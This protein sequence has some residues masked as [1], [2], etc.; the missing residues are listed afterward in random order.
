MTLPAA[1]QSGVV[2]GPELLEHDGRRRA[3][4]AVR[5]SDANDWE[6]D[7]DGAWTPRGAETFLSWGR[8]VEPERSVGVLFRSGS[9]LMIDRWR[10]F[11]DQLEGTT[12]AGWKVAAPRG[13]VA[14]LEFHWPPSAAERDRRLRRWL[15]PRP[16]RDLVDLDSG[17]QVSGR[18]LGGASVD[19]TY[20]DE[21]AKPGQLRLEL[22]RG[23]TLVDAA[24]MRSLRFRNEDVRGENVPRSPVL[25]VVGLA[26]GSVLRV[27][28][29]EK[30]GAQLAIE[31]VDGVAWECDGKLFCESIAFV[32][33]LETDV[34]E[35]TR[36]VFL[37]DLESA[38]YRHVPWLSREWSYQR[39]ANALQGRLRAGGQV[40][41]KGLGMHCTSRLA[42]DL[43][44][45][46]ARLRGA[47]ALDDAAEQEGS[48]VFRVYVDRG[49][50]Q[51]AAVLESPVVRGGDAP[52]PIDLDM[53]GVQRLALIVDAADRGDIR[54][55]ADWL[56]LRLYRP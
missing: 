5:W 48:V 46:F 6:F 35:K 15:E 27:A 18:V 29:L 50:G 24:N 13:R 36:P 30:R 49:D 40:F 53:R 8:L 23:S 45:R 41:V 52:A 38:G 51:W 56:N 42:F 9:L 54:D 31:L 12:A 2:K 34:N 20:D 28:K 26:D 19:E 10:I 22:Q 33:P 3:A 16:A 47:I 44:G 39:D 21:Q 7:L 14:A 55:Y 25:A 37:S 1:A 32:Q 17:D 43:E 11:G 4:A